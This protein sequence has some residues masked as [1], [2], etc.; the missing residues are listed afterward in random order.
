M[1]LSSWLAALCP[2]R[3]PKLRAGRAGSPAEGQSVPEY[4]RTHLL[5]DFA[6]SDSSSIISALLAHTVL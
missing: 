4:K 1:H 5:G 6:A 3:L 2:A